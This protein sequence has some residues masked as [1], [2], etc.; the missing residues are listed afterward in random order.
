MSARCCSS[1]LG[2]G[3]VLVVVLLFAGCSLLDVFDRAPTADFK[4]VP[5]SGITVG[6][7]VRFD[8]S[9]SSD[10]QSYPLSYDWSVMLPS[11]SNAS[12][13]PGGEDQLVKMTPDIAGTYTVALKVTERSHSRKSG[14]TSRSFSVAPAAVSQNE[15][16]VAADK[17]VLAIGYADGDSAVS[18]TENV[19]LPT[20]GAHGT[21]IG[22]KSDRE[23]IVSSS[24]IVTRPSEDT[25]VTLTATITKSGA[26]ETKLF[27]LNVIALGADPIVGSWTLSLVDGQDAVAGGELEN[28]TVNSDN[29][30]RASA[31]WQGTP[32]SSYGT[33][34]A[35]GS[36][37]YTFNYT[38]GGPAGV[39]SEDLALDSSNQTLTAIYNESTYVYV[40]G[41]IVLPPTG[42][43]ASDQSAHVAAINLSWSPSL[44]A[45]VS[46][47][48]VWRGT[49]AGSE[50][51]LVATTPSSTTQYLDSDLEWGRAY[52]YV[53]SAV[54]GTTES[55]VR[56]NEAL[57][58]TPGA[59]TVGVTID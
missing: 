9:S 44:S 11:G 40:P 7:E 43:S 16:D 45:E 17:S 53:V 12:I 21:N 33:W 47:Y 39:S 13:V 3:S 46:E 56:S 5:T 23:A 34:S 2:A 48:R 30:W 38:I 6:M 37:T 22:W 50:P 36:G 4:I 51:T 1:A 20:S 15:I 54:S 32:H 28:F 42:L 14:Q 26:S 8:A 19:I 35:S 57:A 49:A 10:P 18:V 29:S 59:G 55:P 41:S 24:G 27:T 31:V 25:T 52:Y 58:A